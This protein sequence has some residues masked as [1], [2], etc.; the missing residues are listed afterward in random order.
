MGESLR[1]EHS[2]ESFGRWLRRARTDLDL[3]QDALAQRAGIAVRTVRDLEAEKNSN[4]RPQTRRLIIRA[5]DEAAGRRRPSTARPAEVPVRLPLDPP[6]FRGRGAELR[7]LEDLKDRAAA[8]GPMT[9]VISGPPGVGKTALAVRWAHR[10]APSFPDGVLHADL[11]GFTPSV[12][13]REPAEVMTE[14]VEALGVPRQ[15]VPDRPRDLA[16]LYRRTLAGRRVLL[17]LDNARDPEQVRDL[18]PADRG[19][20][21]IVTSR[22]QLAGLVVTSGAHPLVI[23]PCDRDDGLDILAARV[24]RDRVRAEPAAADEILRH[25]GG[26]PLALAVVAARAA[27]RPQFPLAALAGALRDTRLDALE[28]GEPHSDVRSTISWSYAALSD[29]AR[30]IFRVLGVHPLPDVTPAVVAGALGIP[31]ARARAALSELADANLVAERT[32]GRYAMHDLLHAY[33]SE[34]AGD[35]PETLGRL[36]E[37][38]ATTANASAE[39][40][41]PTHRTFHGRQHDGVRPEV[42]AG[43][44]EGLAWFASEREVLLAVMEDAAR[45]GDHATCLSLGSPL[46]TYFDRIGHWTASLMVA[47]HVLTASRHTGPPIARFFGLRYVAR[48]HAKVSDFRTG[49]HYYHHALRVA[50]QLDEPQLRAMAL[51]DLALLLESEGR[52]AESADHCSAVLALSERLPTGSSQGDVLNTRGWAWIC[53][54]DLDRGIPD[55]ERALAL[56]RVTGDRHGQATTL[57]SLGLAHYLSGRHAQAATAYAESLDLARLVGDRHLEA[58]V[59]QHG[60]ENH[61]ATGDLQAARMAWRQALSIMND[62]NP[63]QTYDL[64]A[65]L[66]A[67]EASDGIRRSGR[68][69]GRGSHRPTG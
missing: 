61:E 30:R 22:H 19:S 5:L 25:C 1:A 54:G 37:F 42:F 39:H 23:E 18:L 44:A 53:L 45:A 51:F 43:Q 12:S 7:H 41:C 58:L 35:D 67:L 40:L 6:G 15:Q 3:T 20:A 13:P 65:R 4:P 62:L 64:R 52:Y 26:L 31:T 11:H 68:S 10:S 60:G 32:P 38:Y 9:V 33:A 50:D 21:A 16:L 27:L 29:H 24:G 59:L 14:L 63:D 47:R 56:H 36:R 34:Q 2:G 8:N 49:E 28:T 57:D 46:S 69:E 55:C 17:V 48:G 66:I